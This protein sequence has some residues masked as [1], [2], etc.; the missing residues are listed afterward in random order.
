MCLDTLSV[1]INYYYVING[2]DWF[3]GDHNETIK[4][5]VGKNPDGT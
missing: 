3:W 5:V 2:V 4:F 1:I